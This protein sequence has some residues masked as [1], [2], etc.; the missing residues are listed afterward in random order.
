MKRLIF[1]ILLFVAILI[2]PLWLS[3]IFA[4]F[5]LYYLKS[6]NEIFLYGFMMDIVYANGSHRFTIFFVIMLL[7]SFF[8]KK[9]LKFYSK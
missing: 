1:N 7:L 4:L 9:R 3:F 5:I 6:F 2:C 8:I